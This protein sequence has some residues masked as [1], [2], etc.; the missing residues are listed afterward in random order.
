MRLQLRTHRQVLLTTLGITVL[1]V[2]LAE[3]CVSLLFLFGGAEAF[4]VRNA[5]IFAS[6]FAVS[7][8][9]PIS[10]YMLR[11]SMKLAIAKDKLHALAHTDALTGL[12]NRR[13]FFK[14]ADAILR[15]AAEE[16]I[17]C[18]LLVLDAD[19]FKN[20]N[21]N[22]GHAT[23]DQALIVIAEVLRNNIREDDLCG[24]VGG[25]EFAVLLPNL[26]ADAAE[27]LAQRLVE[28]VAASP[29]VERQAIVEFS[30][31]CGLADTGQCKNLPTLFKA[32]DDAMY[33]AKQDGRNRVVH[34]DFAA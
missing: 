4:H 16:N 7:I 13:S 29:I 8:G 1:T 3:L 18:T 32:A 34:I 23:G 20:L 19:H 9:M 33:Q 15:A 2:V 27:P 14:E 31:S 22:F 24:R 28:S 11:Q 25:E 21:D 17:Y 5:F 10:Y 12:P 30:V 6:I 26:D